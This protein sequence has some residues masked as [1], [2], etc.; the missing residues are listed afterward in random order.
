MNRITAHATFET[1]I[2]FETRACSSKSTVLLSVRRLGIPD[3][4][5]DTTM[6]KQTKLREAQRHAA[7]QALAAR[8]RAHTP[9]RTEPAFITSF[10]E[11]APAYRARIEAYR[12]LALRA[13]EQ[14]RARLRVRSPE[15]R[16]LELVRFTFVNYPIPRHLENAWIDEAPLD[17]GGADPMDGSRPDF[18]R[19][20][21][22][23]GRGASLFR[24]ATHTYMT[25]LETH[26]FLTAPADIVSTQRAFWYA[27]ARA[28]TCDAEVAM[29]VARTKLVRFPVM[30]PFWTEAARFFA[31]NPTTTQE[32]ND[33]IDFFAAKLADQPDFTLTGRS[34]PALRRGMTE[35]NALMRAVDSGVCWPGR[36][37]PDAEYTMCSGGHRMIW[38]FSQIR[39]SGGL[40]REG[41]HMQHC[42]ATY[43]ADCSRNIASIWSL[44]CE[45][46]N[47]AIRKSLTIEVSSRGGVVQCL[48]FANRRP[49]AEEAAV[50]AQWAADHKLELRYGWPNA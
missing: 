37:Q 30:A 34:L 36:P 35:W 46:S 48:G 2:H 14:W 23:A 26:H 16:F 9:A 20:S 19:W 27:F 10:A 15:Q 18:R 38:R 28:Q 7:E 1:R 43:Q 49:N 33:L 50:L 11:F 8:L 42:V 41:Q 17:G 32:M 3:P 25:K 12:D 39:S 6:G 31:R 22:I 13:P 44:T 45:R 29:R 24:E 40:V 4:G 5:S 47:G 21:I